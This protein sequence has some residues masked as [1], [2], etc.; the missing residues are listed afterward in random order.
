MRER[1]EN[2]PDPTPRVFIHV[3]RAVNQDAT[4][5]QLL[6]AEFDSEAKE[7]RQYYAKDVVWEPYQGFD[8]LDVSAMTFAGVR[9]EVSTPSGQS[10]IPRARM[11]TISGA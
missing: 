6:R 9:V 8:I 2:P 3:V 4:T 7:W 5:V 11:R 1:L 10:L